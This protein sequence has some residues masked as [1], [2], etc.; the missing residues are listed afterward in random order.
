[1]IPGKPIK[2]VS[3][4]YLDLTL[5][6]VKNHTPTRVSLELREDELKS[7]DAS[8]LGSSL[9]RIVY[10]ML[11]RAVDSLDREDESVS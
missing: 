8:S 9:Q 11:E 10:E 3:H 7:V 6:P 1:M 5:W 4:L 2:G